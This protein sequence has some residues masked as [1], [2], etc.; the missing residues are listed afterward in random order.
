M[1]GPRT[2][3]VVA[4]HLY[5]QV[6][7][8]DAIRAFA[9]PAGL[10]VLEDAAQ[11]HGASYRGRRAGALG[12][13]ACFSFYP[14]KNLGAFGDGGA[15][16]T[17]DGELAATVRRLRHL[18]QHTKG[19]H[20]DIGG[21]HRLDG[22]QAALLRVKLPHLEAWN[23]ARRKVGARYREALSGHVGLLGER[24]ESP[25]VYHVFPVRVRERNEFARA[26][27]GLGIETQVHYDRVVHAHAAW[28]GH[29]IRGGDVR[30]AEGWAAEELSLPMHPELLAS[31]IERV[32]EAVRR[33]AAARERSPVVG[34]TDA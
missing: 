15:V 21:N 24:A 23:A 6:C 32:V 11:A 10:F 30:R 9:D 20:V 14:S 3:A 13:A 25:C 1:V 7:D 26:L 29:D 27:D 5:G 33:T 19:E 28:I 22:L 12:S 2:A 34:V 18:G 17:D 8:M 31:E 4:V 16:C